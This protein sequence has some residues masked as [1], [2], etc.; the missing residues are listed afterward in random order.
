[1]TTNGVELKGLREL[2]TALDG[3]TFE[4]QDKAT[5]AA[6]RKGATVIKK[7]M[8]L[9][10]PVKTGKLKKSIGTRTKKRGRSAK[11]V[12]VG[13]RKMPYA[14]LVENGHAIVR[15]GKAFG[16]VPAK[17]FLRPAFEAQRVAAAGAIRDELKLQVKKLAGTRKRGGL[18]RLVGGV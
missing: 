5:L 16:H 7:E 13:A 11:S 15:G 8:R 4:V 1:M 17:P 3:F 2:K 12:L 10:V 9:R 14:H 18:A 6:L